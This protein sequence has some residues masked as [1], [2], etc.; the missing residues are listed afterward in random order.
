MSM[1]VYQLSKKLGISN[2]ELLDILKSRGFD[3]AS[4]SSSIADIYAEDFIREYCVSEPA[5]AAENAEAPHKKEAVVPPGDGKSL[6]GKATK[7]AKGH[8]KK[9]LPEEIDVTGEELPM[10]EEG[11]GEDDVDLA[12]KRRMSGSSVMTTAQK[13][14]AIGK[15]S[16]KF[17]PQADKKE[18]PMEKIGENG[19]GSLR[20]AKSGGNAF[21]PDG[22]GGKSEI[23][24]ESGSAVEKA[25]SNDFPTPRFIASP[26]VDGRRGDRA[27]SPFQSDRPNGH[28]TQTPS[29]DGGRSTRSPDST[30]DHGTSGF[31]V[32]RKSMQSLLKSVDEPSTE[33]PR[34]VPLERLQGALQGQTRRWGNHRPDG[35]PLGPGQGDRGRGGF[36]FDHRGGR[37]GDGRGPG[38]RTGGTFGDRNRGR[39]FRGNR[40][41]TASNSAPF[42]GGP[43]REGEG[44]RR[45]R[46]GSGPRGS[47]GNFH[48]DRGRWAGADTRGFTAKAP[49]PFSPTMRRL[50]SPQA[51]EDGARGN[52]KKILS[53]K[54][55]RSVRELAPDVGL[56]PFQIISELM[57]MGIFASMNYVV[58]E[59]LAR[60]LGER[61]GFQ[62]E[63]HRAAAGST[64]IIPLQPKAVAR[65]AVLE[66]RPPV[67]CVLGHVDHGKTT[68]LDSIRKTNVVSG[69]AGGITQHIGAYEIILNDKPI[70]FIDTPGHAAFSKMRERGANVTDIAILVVAADDGFM[71][72]T[73]EALKFAQRAG[74]PVIVAINKIDAKGANI[75][76][77]K[78]QMQQRGISPEDWGG[79]TLCEGVSAITGDGVKR[80][81]ELVLVQAEMLDLKADYGAPAQGVVIESQVEVGRGPT[82]SVIIQQGTLHV[83]DAIVCGEAYCK[84]RAMLDDRG[85]T[86]KAA[87]PAKPCKIIG[88]SDAVDVGA[89]FA[90]AADER[91]AR[92]LAEESR[93]DAIREGSENTPSGYRRSA[94]RLVNRSEEGVEALFAA[95]N[96]K[97]RRALRVIIKGDVQG[98]VEALEACLRGLPQDKIGLEVVRAEVG[99]VVK[100]DVEFA[101]P[102]GATIVAFN[103]KPE[104]GVQALLKQHGIH[105]IQHN[106]IYELIARVRDAMADLLEPEIREEKLGAA[107]VRQIFL[108]SKHAIAG[109]MVTEGKVVRESDAQFRVHRTGRVLF[110]GK[111][112]SLRRAKDDVTEVRAGFECGIALAGFEGYQ[113]G[114]VIE[115]YKVQ[116]IRPSL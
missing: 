88:W 39:D 62:F 4:A 6:A 91:E 53:L 64:K 20:A 116:K 114:D 44:F 45:D 95:I 66:N 86:L 111:V 113:A 48:S 32:Q 55:P 5:L 93:A 87:P 21:V 92:E 84:V 65:D 24:E 17:T 34:M 47:G 103:V 80:L 13:Q 100:N 72:Q 82:A 2:R 41:F 37:P 73:D 115:C 60:R 12:P 81:L 58:D 97:Q 7:R 35:R 76:R 104:S 19:L 23:F 67:V 70:T 107:Q 101:Q 43:R 74:V 3:V 25:P 49:P 9:L 105:L 31:T 51:H 22:V 89:I 71:P 33:R 42:G 78:Q 57:R 40:P 85:K 50:G 112:S 52:E 27:F 99:A 14:G 83:G 18:S 16:K 11:D 79:E 36:P 106:I 46:G 68:L 30:D 15:P 1:R 26:T 90:Q 75:D 110:E 98:S 102:V 8:V 56:K 109:C 94:R 77:V 63:V 59:S 38:N 29:P 69:E 108:L 54:L 96:A 10:M 28:R 61:F